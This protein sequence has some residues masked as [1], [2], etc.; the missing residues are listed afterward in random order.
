MRTDVYFLIQDLAGCA[1]LYADGSARICYFAQRIWHAA[2]RTGTVPRNPG[3][4]LSP[5]ERRAVH[6][7]GWLLLCGTTGCITAAIFITVPAAIA[8]LAHAIDEMASSSPIENIDGMTA[9]IACS[10]FQIV[11]IRTWWRSHGGQVLAYLQAWQQ[12]AAGG[13]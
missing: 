5:P 2:W 8:I 7:Y 11:W 6:A 10:I 3:Q 4:A 13:R 9:L 1:N 12:R